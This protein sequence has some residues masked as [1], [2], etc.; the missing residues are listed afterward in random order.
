M[1]ALRLPILATLVAI[2]LLLAVVAWIEGTASLG[3]AAISMRNA[4]LAEEIFTDDTLLCQIDI[5]SAN[6]A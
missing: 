4:H 1:R 6:K 5:T 3:L 2:C